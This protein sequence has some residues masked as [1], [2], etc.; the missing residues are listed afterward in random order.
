MAAPDH[1]ARD[2]AAR[3]Q[4]APDHAAPSDNT[5]LSDVLEGYADAG[6]ESS[7]GAQEGGTVRC[8]SC[9]A[10]LD[11]SALSIRS[12]RRLEGA[13][14]PDDML[15]VVALE[16]SVCSASGTMV[17]GYGP[18]SSDIDN[19]VLRALPQQRD[20]GELPAHAPPSETPEG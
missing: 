3:D 13:S 8:D 14:D 7:F 17:L 19:D 18:A 20:G 1:P 10:E 11:P 6:F 4:A 15:A 16:C 5:T 12:V 2:Q 9:G